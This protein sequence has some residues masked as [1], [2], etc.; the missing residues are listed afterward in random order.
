MWLSGLKWMFLIIG[1]IIGAG[2]AS[3]RELWEFFGSESGLAIVLFAIL[4]FICCYVLM[5]ISHQNRTEH[6][7]PV[8][9]KLMGKRLT[10][11]YDYMIILYLFSTTIIMIAGGGAT[12]EVLH[13]PYWYGVSIISMLLVLL[14]VWGISGMT[15]MNAVIIPVLIV[16]LVGTLFV[17]QWTTGFEITFDLTAQHNWPTAFTF[18]ALNILPLVAVLAA[19][20]K[21]IRHPGEIWIASFGSALVMG[22][23]S[24]LYNES[25]LIVAHEVMLYEIPLFAIL[26]HYPYFMVL[27]MSGL[28]WAAIYTTAASGMLGLCTR[29]REYVS[30]PFWLIAL[31][32]TALMIPLTTI[33]FS[34][35]I[36][37]LYPLYGLLNLYI[38]AAILLYPILHRFDE[39]PVP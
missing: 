26:K 28:L 32:L 33:G 21:K 14:F 15:S 1:T 9:R 27:V 12:L 11:V 38:L 7:M 29:F 34:T 20:G 23:I 31:V 17:F 13:I 5:T 18:T 3:G 2:Y 30:L 39:R 4:F 36:A 6:Y 25:L 10:G 35:L 22:V 24:F 8:L 37:I 19:I 16:F